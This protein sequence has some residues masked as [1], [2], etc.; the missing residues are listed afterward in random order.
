MHERAPV[1]RQALPQS[2]PAPRWLW[3]VTLSVVA[4]F[5]LARIVV[6]SS[7]DLRTDEAYYW[8]WSQQPAAS[9]LD[10]PP[11]VA[12]F[13]RL[14][15]MLFGDTPFGARFGQ[16]LAVPLI[17]LVFADIARRRTGAMAAALLVVLAIE[18]TVNFGGTGV[19]IEPGI[20]LL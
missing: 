18:S 2:Q 19:I 6:F 3:I 16:F 4:V 1:G 15:T 5:T 9:F 17:E 12:Y 8:T 11:M 13:V 20:P 7:L 14:G 10:Q